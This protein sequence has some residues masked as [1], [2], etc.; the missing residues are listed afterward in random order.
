MIVPHSI[1]EAQMKVV[2]CPCG[3]DVSGETD[4]EIVANVEKHIDEVHPDLVGK[5]SREDIIGMA[6]DH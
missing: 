3:T 2:H 1:E 5:Y 6:H 4:D